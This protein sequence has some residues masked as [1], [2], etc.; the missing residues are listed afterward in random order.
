MET[1]NIQV[2]KKG[3]KG[4]TVTILG[5]FTRHPDDLAQLARNIKSALGTGGT[6]K[7]G[8]IEIQ[9]NFRTQI[10]NVLKRLGFLVK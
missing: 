7:G 5:G 4:K 6:V 2:E 9:G 3:R 1:I 8:C 10:S